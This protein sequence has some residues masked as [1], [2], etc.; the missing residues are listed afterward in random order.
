LTF[1]IYYRIMSSNIIQPRSD[2]DVL[3]TQ[4]SVKMPVTF[5]SINASSIGETD[6]TQAKFIIC[7]VI[8]GVYLVVRLCHELAVVFYRHPIDT[9]CIFYKN[10]KC[11]HP[12]G[13]LKD[14][15]CPP[16]CWYFSC[17]NKMRPP[18]TSWII[19]ILTFA[20]PII[21]FIVSLY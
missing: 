18:F 13:K 17:E 4:M 20:L 15:L 21:I 6:A 12:K 14:K 1:D 7:L 2:I 5:I 8:L 10:E 3:I 16:R 9:G 11:N 19:N